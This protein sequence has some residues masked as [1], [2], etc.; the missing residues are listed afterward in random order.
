MSCRKSTSTTPIL[1]H[2]GVGDEPARGTRP[3]RVM[4]RDHAP[5]MDDCDLHLISPPTCTPGHSHP[6][7]KQHQD[8]REYWLFQAASEGCK[9]CV[10]YYLTTE[11]LDPNSVSL[12]VGYTVLDY[13]LFAQQCGRSDDIVAYM[14]KTWPQ[15]SF[16]VSSSFVLKG[17]TKEDCGSTEDDQLLSSKRGQSPLQRTYSKKCSIVKKLLH[18]SEAWQHHSTKILVHE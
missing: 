11:Q 12:N 17:N 16:G 2:A 7:S 4:K 14:T 1:E 3:E 15:I 8:I 6:P 18:G 13:A 5:L 9:E 10:T